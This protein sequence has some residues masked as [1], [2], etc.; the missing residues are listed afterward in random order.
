MQTAI[1][2]AEIPAETLREFFNL[3]RVGESKSACQ[4]S[5]KDT[6][7]SIK[8]NTDCKEQI[9]ECATTMNHP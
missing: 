2:P 6:G 3:V 8:D 9:Q 1:R 4:S 5:D 7:N